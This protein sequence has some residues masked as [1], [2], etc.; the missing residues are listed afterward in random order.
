M[1]KKKKKKKLE[2]FVLLGIPE[3]YLSPNFDMAGIC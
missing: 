3:F 2:I 1:L